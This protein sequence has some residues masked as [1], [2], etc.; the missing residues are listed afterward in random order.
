MDTVLLVHN[1]AALNALPWACYLSQR[2]RGRLRVLVVTPEA[3]PGLQVVEE[4]DDDAPALVR[5]TFAAVTESGASP[6]EIHCCGGVRLRRGA[7]NALA[8][9]DADL[10]IMHGTLTGERRQER[11][12]VRELTRAA[13]VDTLI[14]D[15]G[16]SVTR[17][18]RVFFVQLG[19]SGSHGMRFALRSFCDADHPLLVI[20]DPEAQ[21]RSRRAFEKLRQRAGSKRAA[22]LELLPTPASMDELI[23]DAVA[24]GDL[25]LVD[26]DDPRR[27]AKRLRHLQKLREARPDTA[28]SIGVTRADSLVGVGKLRRLLEHFHR[29]VPK[30]DREA[31][32]RI[33][34]DLE[35]GGSVSMDFVIM[36]MLSAGIATLGLVQSSSAVVIG[37]MLVAPLMTPMLATGLALVQGNFQQ[38]RASLR[39][40][41][42][43]IG[44]ALLTAM[45]IGW[46]SPWDDLSTEVVARGAPNLFDLAIAALSGIAAAYSL[47]RPG[48]AGTLVGVAVAVA[49]VPP[50]CAVGIATVKSQHAIATGAAVLFITNLL[51]I[52]L[53]AALVFRLFGLDV[54]LRGNQAPRW[55][56][57][58]L[59][60]LGIALL[61][62]SGVLYANLET[63]IHEGVQRNYSRPLP[64]RLRDAINSRVDASPRASVLI[65]EQSGIEQGFDMHVAIVVDGDPDPT[66]KQDILDLIGAEYGVRH[67]ATVLLLRSATPDQ[68]RASPFARGGDASRNP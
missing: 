34:T 9:L 23:G 27:V 48:L 5:Q 66:L 4:A 30:L 37:G 50:L 25:V 39:A 40:M 68:H 35:R 3:A 13:P 28:F 38:F 56:Q 61:P 26:S 62:V 53:G 65:M 52:I 64:K 58:T 63:Q 11:S 43:G 1:D 16:E 6:P 32:R 7:L 18:D 12:L 55:V 22:A 57:A 10:L 24:G 49:L 46:L 54:S 36:L 19:G 15:V 60:A 20:P 33:A 44:G 45:L 14:L 21:A 17:P 51:A 31:R 29:H 41:A 8:E 42:I 2:Q 59:A 67:R 47:S